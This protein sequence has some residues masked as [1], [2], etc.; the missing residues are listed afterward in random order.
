M[1]KIIYHSFLLLWVLWVG[2]GAGDAKER[3]STPLP[4]TT[5]EQPQT[6][7]AETVRPDSASTAIAPTALVSPAPSAERATS[8]PLAAWVIPAVACVLFLL[9]L[10]II[11][12]LSK[13]RT[14]KQRLRKLEHS[15]EAPLRKWE[16]NRQQI[17]GKL[18]LQEEQL[19]RLQL[20]QQS[21]HSKLETLSTTAPPQAELQ[22]PPVPTPPPVSREAYF[23]RN[24]QQ[25]F[26]SVSNKYE[27]TSVF[28]V[29]FQ[30]E[31]EGTFVLVDLKQLAYVA[32]ISEVIQYDGNCD[33]RQARQ[34]TL[35]E[36]GHVVRS[37]ECWRIDRPLR[38]HVSI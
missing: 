27:N 12:S 10:L 20:E 34:F 5:A 17:E 18:R 35:I 3:P 16:E 33:I 11:V 38:I 22:T 6:S 24:V 4:D 8:R 1:K 37:G 26:T 13:I 15:R 36:P 30:S 21:L 29:T 25:Y 28:K 14:L 7:A 2:T 23:G 31:N 32:E 9:L 19:R